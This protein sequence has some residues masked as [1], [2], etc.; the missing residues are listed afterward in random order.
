MVSCLV[1][2]LLLRELFE[3]F[4]Y[5]RRGRELMGCK[6]PVCESLNHHE[7]IEQTQ[8]EGKGWLARVGLEE[9]GVQSYEP[10][11]RNSI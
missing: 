5:A 3:L 6:S 2:H 8:A 4:V 11:N 7:M 1:K 10:T 9:A